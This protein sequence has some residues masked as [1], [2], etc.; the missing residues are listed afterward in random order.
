MYFA[1]FF[2]LII[3]ILAVIFGI[4]NT[5]IVT[6]KLFGFKLES[7]L[8]L[9]LLVFLGIGIILTLLFSIPYFVKNKKRI[10]QLNKRIKELE[11]KSKRLEEENKTLSD[12]REIVQVEEE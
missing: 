1:L 6:L 11:E 9:I 5:A 8:A 2:F 12:S 7:S 10:S 4:Q 3:A